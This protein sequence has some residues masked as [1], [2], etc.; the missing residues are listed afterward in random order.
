MEAPNVACGDT[1]GCMYFALKVRAL[2]WMVDQLGLTGQ[3]EPNC[4]SHVTR[5]LTKLP[6]DMQ[7]EFMRFYADYYSQFPVFP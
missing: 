2:I 7:A 4:V 6:Q 1:S 5:Q 3:T